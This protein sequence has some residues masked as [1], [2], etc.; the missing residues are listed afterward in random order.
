MLICRKELLEFVRD[1]KLF[2]P[3]LCLPVGLPI[4]FQF[5][6]MGLPSAPVHGAK[7]A[8]VNAMNMMMAKLCPLFLLML[9]FIAMG[10]SL[11]MAVE[12]FVGEKE[13]KTLEPLL[14]APISDAQLFVS[15]CLAATAPPVVMTYLA[16]ALFV[17]LTSYRLSRAGIALPITVEQVLFLTIFVPLVALL[18]CSVAAIVSAWAS[19]VKSASQMAGFVVV[20]FVMLL[21]F[22]GAT[23]LQSR[24]AM[25]LTLGGML[26]ADVVTLTAGCMLFRRDRLVY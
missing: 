25:A 9:A 23:I 19:S 12:S 3:F 11:G 8:F 2:I 7:P 24:M 5:I 10:F 18:M 20:F 14:A 26:A 17:L 1:R 6:L 22:Q 16:E 4:L 21:Q 15:K 13:R